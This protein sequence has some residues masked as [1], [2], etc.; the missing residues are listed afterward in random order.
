M[1]FVFLNTR[2]PPF[3]D[4]R[5]RR[6]F[7]YAVDRDAV[8]RAVGGPK[9]AQPFCQLRPPSV[10][11]F[12]AYC[13]YTA[14]PSPTGEWKAPDLARAR[15][16]VAASGTRGMKVT[17]WTWHGNIDSA[18]RVAASA[19][20]RLGYRTRL[21][22]VDTIDDYFP[23][24]LDARTRAQA[25]MFGWIGV[26]GSPPSYVLKLSLTCGSIRPMPQ[27]NNPSFFCDR[28]I[29]AQIARALA[30]QAVDP[31]AAASRWQEVERRL[32][33]RAPWVPLFTPERVDVVSKRVRNFQYNPAWGLLLDQLWVQ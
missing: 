27:N 19:L 15:R 3:D 2:V 12:R 22:W 31:E 23:K 29:D 4:V 16:L 24:V 25:G 8:A 33:D 30:V 20:Q 13:P 5:V 11:G 18:A 21:R 6:A 28:R 17:L 32:V 9:L 7:N 14:D 1:F 10:T 26:A